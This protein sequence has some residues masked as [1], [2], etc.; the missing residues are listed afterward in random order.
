MD[1]EAGWARRDSESE[2]ELEPRIGR[3]FGLA[4]P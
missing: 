2:S 3:W 1:R 4:S